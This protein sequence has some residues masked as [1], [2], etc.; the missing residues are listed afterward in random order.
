MQAGAE[1]RGHVLIDAGALARL[2]RL[3]DGVRIVRIGE[4]ATF[5]PDPILELMV[6]G[7]AVPAGGR[8]DEVPDLLFRLAQDPETGTTNLSLAVRT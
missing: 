4:R 5:G 1:R 3:P 7:A 2:L 6:E 8:N